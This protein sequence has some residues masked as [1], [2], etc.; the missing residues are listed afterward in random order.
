MIFKTHEEKICGKVQIIAARLLHTDM[1]VLFHEV[2]IV[3]YCC[4][5]WNNIFYE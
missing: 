4:K 2:H 3:D 1:Q 5:L